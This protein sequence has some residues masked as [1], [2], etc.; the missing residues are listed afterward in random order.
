MS[1][2]V[3]TFLRSTIVKCPSILGSRLRSRATKLFRVSAMRCDGDGWESWM[4]T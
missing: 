4:A 3:P 2:V 1:Y